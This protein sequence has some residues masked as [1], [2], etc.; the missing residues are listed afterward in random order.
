ML[1]SPAM[2]SRRGVKGVDIGDVEGL[3]EKGR[4]IRKKYKALK[5]KCEA[6]KDGKVVAAA[7]IRRLADDLKK[8]IDEAHAGSARSGFTRDASRASPPARITMAQPLQ[9]SDSASRPPAAGLGRT[10]LGLLRWGANG[11][12][13]RT[14]R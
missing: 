11:F 13:S 3:L 4:R 10:L 5:K 1:A 9:A 7:E 12:G 14:R 6:S 2:A 8:A